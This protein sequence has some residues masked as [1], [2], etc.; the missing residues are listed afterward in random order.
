[1]NGVPEWM[2]ELGLTN[3]TVAAFVAMVRAGHEEVGPA[4]LAR[5]VRALAAANENLQQVAADAISKSPPPIVI[6]LP[7][8]VMMGRLLQASAPEAGTELTPI[9]HVDPLSL[10]ALGKLGRYAREND[11]LRKLVVYAADRD[12]GD[13]YIHKCPWCGA[14]RGSDTKVSALIEPH[15][16][17]CRAF[18]PDG[19]LIENPPPVQCKHGTGWD[20]PDCAAEKAR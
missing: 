3:P 5:M 4:L 7:S 6:N 20:C 19:R 10:G 12:R 11:R 13:G 17:D 1:M 2:A 18:H 15:A 8:D 16:D 9:L 14:Y